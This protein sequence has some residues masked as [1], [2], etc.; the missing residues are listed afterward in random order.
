MPAPT[1]ARGPS[2]PPEV[3]GE[4]L[5]TLTIRLQACS[6]TDVSA[7]VQFWGEQTYS[8]LCLLR[9]GLPFVESS[10]I[11]YPLLGSIHDLCTYL[12]DASPL[13][14]TF[15]RHPQNYQ[16]FR[17]EGIASSCVQL[18][19]V[20]VGYAYLQDICIKDLTKG[21]FEQ[22]CAL[23]TIKL[24]LRRDTPIVFPDAVLDSATIYI[25]EACFELLFRVLVCPNTATARMQE[26]STIKGL[27]AHQALLSSLPT[28]PPHGILQYIN[29]KSPLA[30]NA[31]INDHDCIQSITNDSIRKPNDLCVGG[32]EEKHSLLEEL[33][34]LC[35][36]DMTIPT[37]DSAITCVDPYEMWISRMIANASSPPAKDFPS[38]LSA[39]SHQSSYLRDVDTMKL[40][41]TG[42]TLLTRVANAP[43]GKNDFILQYNPPPLTLDQGKAVGISDFIV[44]ERFGKQFKVK[45]STGQTPPKGLKPRGNE[46]VISVLKCAYTRQMEILFKNDDCV[47]MWLDG[48]VDFCLC[49]RASRA[50]GNSKL[51]RVA[52][53]VGQRKETNPVRKPG[54]MCMA[55]ACLRLRDVVLSETLS[56]D[57][58]LDLLVTNNEVAKHIGEVGTKVGTLTVHVGLY[59]DDKKAG[60]P[61]AA[62]ET[63]ILMK[64]PI[65][66]STSTPHPIS[67]LLSNFAGA[68]PSSNSKCV[69]SCQLG[70]LETS[71][72]TQQNEIP[73]NS[74]EQNTTLQPVK[75][76]PAWLDIRIERISKLSGDNIH[77]QSGCFKLGMTCNKQMLSPCEL[78]HS[79][80]DSETIE[81]DSTEMLKLTSNDINSIQNNVCSWKV[82]LE[83]ENSRGNLTAVTLQMWYCENASSQRLVGT[84]TIP[85]LVDLSIISERK[86]CI[87]LP[88]I[89]ANSRFDLLD[90]KSHT[91]IGNVEV[92]VAAGLLRQVRSFSAVCQHAVIVQRWWRR[93][94]TVAKEKE[95]RA[96]HQCLPTKGIAHQDYDPE[97]DTIHAGFV[98]QDDRGLKIL[99][100]SASSP[101]S[102]FDEWSQQSLLT[103]TDGYKSTVRHEGEP[104]TAKPP[105]DEIQ[106]AA[107]ASIGSST[108]SKKYDIN[109]DD[110]SPQTDCVKPKPATS[111][112]TTCICDVENETR[113]EYSIPREQFNLI[114]RLEKICG[115]R[116]ILSAW[117]SEQ[118]RAV[119]EILLSVSGFFVSFSQDSAIQSQEEELRKICSGDDSWHSKLIPFEG[120]ARDAEVNLESI[121]SVPNYEHDTENIL[122]QT[123]QFKLWFVPVITTT[124]AAMIDDDKTKDIISLKGCT[125]IST[126]KCPLYH[127]YSIKGYYSGRL[128]WSMVLHGDQNKSYLGCIS[129]SIRRVKIHPCPIRMLLTQNERHSPENAEQCH[130]MST[131]KPTNLAVTFSH[132]QDEYIRQSVGIDPPEEIKQDF[133]PPSSKRSPNVPDE[134]IDYKRYRVTENFDS[135]CYP[136]METADPLNEV[137]HKSTTFNAQDT[138]DEPEII[139][140]GET[141]SFGCDQCSDADDAITY[142]SLTSMIGSLDNINSKLT[143]GA[144]PT[145]KFS[146]SNDLLG[147]SEVGAKSHAIDDDSRRYELVNSPAETCIPSQK[148]KPDCPERQIEPP[149]ENYVSRTPVDQQANANG[150]NG[151]RVKTSEKGSSPMSTTNPYCPANRKFDDT[152]IENGRDENKEESHKSAENK[153]SDRKFDEPILNGNFNCDEVA[154]GHESPRNSSLDRETLGEFA[155]HYHA[156]DW[157]RLGEAPKRY[158]S[159]LPVPSNPRGILQYHLGERQISVLSPLKF[160]FITRE[161]STWGGRVDS[162]TGKI[163]AKTNMVDKERLERIFRS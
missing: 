70:S 45:T 55:K 73:N 94:R 31:N 103:N 54:C 99:S 91:P 141:S 124:I 61:P 140:H 76:P 120:V 19:P 75:V 119:S 11:E 7:R 114:V 6:L 29:T 82:P 152:S 12:I 144:N 96:L 135:P 16:Q 158:G 130:V 115:I 153:D 97:F 148:S 74:N 49:Y 108:T 72:T 24:S 43:S 8:D 131:L 63:Q 51:P 88:C 116:E 155:Q 112:Q 41:V 80:I 90:P 110:E 65:S 129:T 34:D 146:A 87:W 3:V 133:L 81:E 71:K 14:V 50:A 32:D 104:H 149:E 47:R 84:A 132:E 68:M 85:F 123:L 66:F 30:Q 15:L 122:T 21:Y 64:V 40:V 150:C 159:L 147:S 53:L 106:H 101:D 107:H 156:R 4:L 145:V 100:I 136:P 163:R 89:V 105:G 95:A 10:A 111:E 154:A 38:L 109:D 37:V 33:L 126:A 60:S 157:R 77:E 42:M 13:K 9:D 118:G 151:D 143:R 67:V 44:C 52:M 139:S 137:W 27:P 59:A 86:L 22:E 92:L 117:C 57:G 23:K 2:L 127:L 5:G 18:Q 113:K 93:S 121:I 56:F 79:Q 17:T 160:D 62:R 138:C 20:I 142:R 46:K 26:G 1:L 98:S 128:P 162:S 83:A 39:G 102:L 78:T 36:D 69:S 25:G 28:N 161:A 48:T 35:S 125:V 134:P 58:K